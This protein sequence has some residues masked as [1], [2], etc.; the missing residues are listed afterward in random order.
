MNKHGLRVPISEIKT[1]NVLKKCQWLSSKIS[2]MVII[3]DDL[4]T[5]SLQQYNFQ[6]VIQT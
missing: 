2:D 4:K 6:S 5:E 3:Y 1:D